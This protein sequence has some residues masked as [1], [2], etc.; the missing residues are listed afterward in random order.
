[1]SWVPDIQSSQFF[2]PQRTFL[3]NEKIKLAP[4]DFRLIG[5]L[6]DKLHI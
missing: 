2:R 3:L 6:V 4:G 5:Y 1:M